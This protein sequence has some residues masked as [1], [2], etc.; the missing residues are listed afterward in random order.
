[1]NNMAVSVFVV[2]LGVALFRLLPSEHELEKLSSTGQPSALSLRYLQALVAANPEDEHLRLLL[3]R[4]LLASGDLDGAQE[5]LSHVVDE[6]G[7]AFHE[8]K[9]LR[10]S[11]ALL[12]FRAKN[13]GVTE[14]ISE[15]AIRDVLAG[16]CEKET[17][18]AAATFALEIG[19]PGLAADTYERLARQDASAR[20][21]W[22]VEAA[23]W[24]RASGDDAHAASLYAEAADAA[25][26][27]PAKRERAVPGPV[28]V[29][30]PNQKDS[31]L[32]DKQVDLDRAIALAR[33]TYQAQTVLELRL[34]CAEQPDPTD[35]C[36]LELTQAYED[37]G[38]PDAASAVLSAHVKRRGSRALWK[39]LAILDENRGAPRE[40]IDAWQQVASLAPLDG[41]EAQLAAGLQWRMDAPREALD[42]LV[43][44]PES[45]PGRDVAYWSMVS[46][47]AWEINDAAAALRALAELRA[48]GDT[49]DDIFDRIISIEENRENDSGAATAALEA[50]RLRFEPKMLFTAASLLDRQKKDRE[51]VTILAS[52]SSHD[53][54]LFEL[55]EYWTR[56]A[57]ALEHL[58]ETAEACRAYEGALRLEPDSPEHMHAVFTCAM[59]VADV[60]EQRGDSAEALRV[61]R[62]A[63]AMLSP[64]MAEAIKAPRANRHTRDA[65]LA[66]AILARRL[67]GPGAAYPWL[68]YLIPAGDEPIDDSDV[69][70]LA[71]SYYL[72]D[73]N[74]KLA[75]H[76][77]RRAHGLTPETVRNTRLALALMA[78]DIDE[79]ERLLP[80]I[81]ASDSSRIDALIRTG[82]DSEAMGAIDAEIKSANAA[83]ERDRIRELRLDRADLAEQASSSGRT[84]YGLD[85]LGSL[86]IHGPRLEV[87]APYDRVR[88]EGDARWNQISSNAVPLP[89]GSFDEKQ[90]S[91]AFG[92]R[93]LRT[94]S[95]LALG[96][97]LRAGIAMPQATASFMQQALGRLTL[98]EE[99]TFQ[100]APIDTPLIR[101]VGV[102]DAGKVEFALDVT[103]RDRIELDGMVFQERT[104]HQDALGIGGRGSLTVAHRLLDGA[105][106]WNVYATGIVMGR[107]LS[108]EAGASLAGVGIP[109]STSPNELLPEMAV[110]AAI[111]TQLEHGDPMSPWGRTSFPRYSIGISAGRRWPDDMWN[112][113]ARAGIGTRVFGDDVFGLAAYYGRGL[114]GSGADAFRGGILYYSHGL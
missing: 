43:S 25:P 73:G 100:D 76:T 34:R 95:R 83:V 2:T 112:F 6:K 58:G 8:T 37:V 52:A 65:I 57:T 17:L 64:R 71:I 72:A 110:M 94:N 79:L 80:E 28:P 27:A 30:L 66:R 42:A 51:V 88:F 93:T 103:S 67:E 1:M 54:K 84:S 96:A 46:D 77:L 3:A 33:T 21:A 81:P 41:T 90:G 102:R 4:D 24:R 89:I 61:R 19:R 68:D 16:S 15:H 109:A 87:A 5:S 13:A 59:E 20:A 11:I 49:S 105:P 45:A 60:A 26:E 85:A 91:L 113:E 40:A 35:S 82:R 63:L 78:N 99:I 92:Y 50:Y 74:A 56:R 18:E 106:D 111:G 104:I 36:I 7:P 114:V 22:L 14:E 55:P 12:R 9:K 23:R 47:L 108:L 69:A 53:D 107:R 44:V 48:R 70:A 31:R 98:R 101:A 62:E 39:R 32:V 75:K 29:D 10:M 97:N 38:D 86:L